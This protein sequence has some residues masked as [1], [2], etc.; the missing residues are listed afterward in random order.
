MNKIDAIYQTIR[1]RLLNKV[2]I[3]RTRKNLI[4]SVIYSKDLQTQGMV[5]PDSDFDLT[6]ETLLQHDTELLTQLLNRWNKVTIDPKWERF[7]TF[8]ETQTTTDKTIVFSESV[9]TLEYLT[10]KITNRKPLFVHAGNRNK[11]RDVLRRNFDANAQDPADDYDLLLTSDVLAEGINLHRAHIIVHYDTPWNA[12]KM[13]QRVGRVNRLGAT[14]DIESY[15]FYPSR[16]GDQVINL[17]NNAFTKIQ[18]LEV[19]FGEEIRVL[20]PQEVQRDYKLYNDDLQDDDFQQKQDLLLAVQEL[21]KNNR[22]LYEKI[23]SLPPKC[24]CL[25]EGSDDS[26]VVFIKRDSKTDYFRVEG[27]EIQP[28]SLLEVVKYLKASPDE[29]PLSMPLPERHYEGVTQVLKKVQAD[30][31]Q[32][33]NFSPSERQAIA[34]LNRQGTDDPNIRSLCENLK[35]MLVRGTLTSLAESINKSNDLRTLE[36]RIGREDH[37]KNVHTPPQVIVSETFMP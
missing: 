33:R 19:A 9:N 15:V 25:R 3:R 23:K 27:T 2:T 8:L 18:S 20:S 37:S 14:H 4:E 11:V 12:T 32:Q 10:T 22:S 26:T 24:A 31:V 36:N 7:K 28:L 21:Y 34:K 35:G 30:V 6:I 29:K 16:Q 1:E 5:F 13:L 17:F